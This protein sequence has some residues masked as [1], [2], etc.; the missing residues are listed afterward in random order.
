MKAK[1][2]HRAK[3]VPQHAVLRLLL[4]QVSSLSILTNK[5]DSH[6][7]VLILHEL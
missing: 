6:F 3:P 2:G 7:Q 4:S 5:Y 1:Q